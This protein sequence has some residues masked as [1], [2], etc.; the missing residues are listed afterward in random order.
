[1]I[2]FPIAELMD[3]S[4]YII[5]LE[6]RLHPHSLRC[7]HCG[8]SVRRLFHAQDH[9]PAYRYRACGDYKP[10]QNSSSAQ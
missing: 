1:M 4:I 5:W 8:Q 7:L 2:D 6:R 3:D 9:F 10:F